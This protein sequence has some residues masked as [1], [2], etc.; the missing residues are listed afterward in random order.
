MNAGIDC[1]QMGSL[2]VGELKNKLTDKGLTLSP[3]AVSSVVLGCPIDS[4]QEY[5]TPLMHQWPLTHTYAK[6]QYVV[7]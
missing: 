7:G 1:P 4:A 2:K 3:L 6:I 5:W